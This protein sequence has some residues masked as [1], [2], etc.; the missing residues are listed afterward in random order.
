MS[1]EFKVF[2]N[3]RTLRAQARETSLEVLE[4]LLEKMTS[5]VEDRLQ[6]EESGKKERE[7]KQAKLV[8]IR[9]QLLADGI[10]PKELIGNF[11]SAPR[12]QKTAPGPKKAK[13]KYTNENGEEKSWTGQGRTP[14]A[15]AV[16]IDSG[17]KLEDFLI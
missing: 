15:I 16:A 3:L 13:Y 6:E 7:E 5:I 10:D 2:S 9:E 17:K 8:A 11:D 12:K 1:E 14:K 4:D